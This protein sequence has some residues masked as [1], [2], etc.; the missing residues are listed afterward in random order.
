MEVLIIGGHGFIGKNMAK[1]FD[2]EGH[3]VTIIDKKDEESEF[4]SYK[5]DAEDLL[6]EI[7]FQSQVFDNVLYLAN[8]IE[9]QENLKGFH[10]ILKLAMK[11]NIRQFFVLKEDV[12][13]RV[14]NDNYSAN[15]NKISCTDF[16]EL[17]AG[18]VYGPMQHISSYDNE[19]GLSLLDKPQNEKYW[20]EK[21]DD[22]LIDGERYYYI[23]DIVDLIYKL[24]KNKKIGVIKLP[25]DGEIIGWEERYTPKLG[26]QAT[27][28][29]YKKSNKEITKSINTKGKKKI[30]IGRRLLPYAENV[31]FFA[32][33]FAI[34]YATR[35]EMDR[36]E[37]FP[38]DFNLIYVF[39]IGIVY[40]M[41]QGIIAI[42][43]AS[44]AHIIIHTHTTPDLSAVIYNELHMIQLVMYVIVA[45]FAS[46]IVGNYKRKVNNLENDLEEAR[47]REE[48]LKEAYFNVIDIKN[49][50][51]EQVLRSD[52]NMGKMLSYSKELGSLLPEDVI[53][54]AIRVLEQVMDS[55]SICIYS[56]SEEDDFLRLIGRSKTLVGKVR[57]SIN[58][59]TESKIKENV[60]SNQIFINTNLEEGLP[61]MSATI[62]IEGKVR[63]VIFINDIPFEQ[64]NL[65]YANYLR[66]CVG[67]VE[68]NIKRAIEHQDAI[69]E[70]SFYLDTPIIVYEHFKKIVESKENAKELLNIQFTLVKFKLDSPLQSQNT[71]NFIN[72]INNKIRDTDYMGFD[73]ENG[74]YLLCSNADIEETNLVIKR[75]Q[76]GVGRFGFDIR[77]KL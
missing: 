29:W 53:V 60:I 42:I 56:Y 63:T 9:R 36:Y 72:A 52:N 71:L 38:V 59:K 15:V 5:L 21:V 57:N 25:E 54:G 34:S 39:I 17:H 14:I 26:I 67:M 58:L 55:E 50:L 22:E 51:Q 32:L 37:I 68:G 10:N 62:L 20:L 6:C 41:K 35:N 65:Y 61:M 23:D 76:E 64:L 40:G 2:K 66:V 13:D 19:I 8:D 18:Y 1:K 47:D 7:V 74:V 69:S 16:I 4:T 3:R 30:G 77:E 49:D 45:I 27:A 43:F 28:D 33:F 24:I 12:E 70:K 11:Y 73:L 44:L 31:L 75:L 46:Y 48:L